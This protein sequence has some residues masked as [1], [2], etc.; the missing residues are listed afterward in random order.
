[1]IPTAIKKKIL[2]S[3]RF[4][5][6]IDSCGEPEL[7]IE[8]IDPMADPDKFKIKKEVLYKTNKNRTVFRK[9][10]YSTKI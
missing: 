6:Y 7:S 1:M 9:I 3:E 2:S 5:K 4:Y 10:Y 8:S